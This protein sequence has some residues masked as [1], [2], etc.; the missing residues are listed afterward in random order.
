MHKGRA[1]V[2]ERDSGLLEERVWTCGKSGWRFVE[3]EEAK[4][5]VVDGD[6]A[7]PQGLGSLEEGAT[8]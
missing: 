6:V 2:E 4:G 7:V 3:D 5:M 8:G 1:W